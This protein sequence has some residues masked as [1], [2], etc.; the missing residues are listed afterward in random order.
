MKRGRRIFGMIAEGANFFG[1]AFIEGRRYVMN[2][3]G[4]VTLTYRFASH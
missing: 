4:T 3:D 1:G 2:D